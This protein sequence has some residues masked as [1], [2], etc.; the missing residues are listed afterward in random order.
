MEGERTPTRERILF[1]TAELF[2]RQGYSGTGLKQ[3]VA[4]AEAPFG[5]LY[6]HFPGGK[7]QLAEEVIH[8]GGAFFGALVEAVYDAGGPERPVGE[9]IGAVFAGAA[10]TLEAT[11]FQ[12]AC[13][14]ATIALEVAST[15]DALRRATAE[16]FERWTSALTERLGE[17]DVALAV[18]AALEGAF[19][20][21]RAG[22]TTEPMRAAGAMAAAH[23]SG[24]LEDRSGDSAGQPGDPMA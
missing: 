21:C 14:I 7:G 3:I 16:V 1:A 10:Q 17:R 12:D 22:R 11:D 4:A 23:V 19:V 8:G 2:R 15:D 13:P 5:S 24:R 18:I 20:L 9:S 6:H